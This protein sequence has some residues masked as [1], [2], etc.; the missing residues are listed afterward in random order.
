[1]I[2][3]LLEIIPIHVLDQST[4]AI[5]CTSNF[6][7][8]K[9]SHWSAVTGH[10]CACTTQAAVTVVP[11]LQAGVKTPFYVIFPYIYIV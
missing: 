4:I 6:V 3:S 2:V 7:S 1:M 10:G 9:V 11:V 8:F 5:R